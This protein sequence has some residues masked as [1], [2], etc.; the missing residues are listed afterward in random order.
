MT[1]SRRSCGGCCRWWSPSCY[2][3]SLCFPLAEALQG[4]ESRAWLMFGI[5]PRARQT[6][7]LLT[8]RCSDICSWSFSGL[9]LGMAPEECQLLVLPLSQLSGA[10]DGGITCCPSLLTQDTTGLHSGDLTAEPSRAG[11][12]RLQMVEDLPSR[13]CWEGGLAECAPAAHKPL[14]FPTLGTPGT[15]HSPLSCPNGHK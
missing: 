8:M 2:S 1:G 10:R 3:A 12:G 4:T 5:N 13:G 11:R 15:F 7:A 9:V 14:P 6:D